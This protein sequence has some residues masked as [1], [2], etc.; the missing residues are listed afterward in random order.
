MVL[1]LRKVT[2]FK[3]DQGVFDRIVVLST[4]F[5]VIFAVYQYTYSVKPIFDKEKELSK[6]KIEITE[7]NAEIN[8]KNTEALN[9]QNDIKEKTKISENLK[10]EIIKFEVEKKQLANQVKK[11]S[12][13]ISE[14]NNKLVDITETALEA[15]LFKHMNEIMRDL[16]LDNL[17]RNSTLSKPYVL[18]YVEKELSNS[19]LDD[20]EINALKIIRE[21]SETEMIDNSYEPTDIYGAI[22]YKNN[23]KITE[24]EN[25][26][27]AK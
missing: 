12:E 9:L 22:I 2:W 19:H 23:K 25:K 17:Y 16:M 15:H 20:V 18:E 6:S 8:K 4:I 10:S 21:Y 3:K 24:K 7:L 5:G 11:S 1:W 13:E 27:V 26:P 14:I